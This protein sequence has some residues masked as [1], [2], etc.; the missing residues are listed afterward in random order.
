MVSAENNEPVISSRP[1]SDWIRT[2]RTF[3]AAGACLTGLGGAA[4]Y[5]WY[6][7]T[8]PYGWSHC[9]DRVL[10]FKLSDYA[11]THNGKFPA[12][13]ATPEASLSLLA[14]EEYPATA[15]SLRGKTVPEE[16]VQQ[17]LDRGELLGPET[18][19]WHYV[20]GLAQDDD[21]AL[22]LFWDKAGLGHNGQRLSEP[23]HTVWY[24][25][26]EHRFIPKTEWSQFLE[27]Q[28]LLIEAR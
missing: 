27:E 1:R 25:S 8:F 3:A 17:V 18:C 22:A 9:C 6:V 4:L 2:L 13:E 12:G 7:V 5:A 24:V 28:W 20:E 11:Q 15:N 26:G 10:F 21:P 19:G 14:R 16:M 23:G